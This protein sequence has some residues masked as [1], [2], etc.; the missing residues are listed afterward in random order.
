[1]RA[2][3]RGRKVHKNERFNNNNHLL[4]HIILLN[5][6]HRTCF[7]VVDTQSDNHNIEFI[8]VHVKSA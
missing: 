7:N 5:E 1:M 3:A 6:K 8:V 2:C 4:S